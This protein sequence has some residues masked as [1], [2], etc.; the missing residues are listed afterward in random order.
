MKNYHLA[1]FSLAIFLFPGRKVKVTLENH[2]HLFLLLIVPPYISFLLLLLG[3]L[4][5][6]FS[7]LYFL[8][9]MQIINTF[10]EQLYVY[11]AFFQEMC[12]KCDMMVFFFILIYF[13]WRLITLQYCSGPSIYFYL[14]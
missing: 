6:L 11:K 10:I 3:W 7:N 2:L 4:F 5:N 12:V 13:N 9:L 1:Y 14:V 8:R